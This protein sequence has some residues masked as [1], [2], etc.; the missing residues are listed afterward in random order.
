MSCVEWGRVGWGFAGTLRGGDGVRKFVLSYGVGMKT[1]SFGLALSHCY[2][3][4]Q[5]FEPWKVGLG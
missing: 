3:Y 4:I 5:G 2:L 1:P